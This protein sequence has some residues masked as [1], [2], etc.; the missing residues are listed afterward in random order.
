[1][2]RVLLISVVSIA[3]LVP[4]A[5][6]DHTPAA[7]PTPLPCTYTLSTVALS[8][9]ATGGSGSVAVTTAVGCAWTATSDRAWI[10]IVSSASGTGNGTVEVSVAANVSTGERAG[11]LTIAG[12]PVAV[13]V[14]ALAVEPCTFDLS[15]ASATFDHASGTGSFTVS[16]PDGCE[17]TA[18]SRVAWLAVTSGDHGSG[19]GRVAYAVDN[20]GTPDSR[21]GMIAIA[22]RMFTVTQSGSP[23]TCEYSVAPVTVAA[24]MSVPY[25]M[26]TTIAT[27]NGCSWT[28]TAGAPWISIRNQTGS[29]PATVRFTV[30][31]NWDAPRNSLVMIRWPTPTAGQNVQIAQA[32]CRY[33]VSASSIAVEA[34]GGSRSFD[35]YQ[36]SDP[37]D[38][39]GPLQDACVWTAQSGADWITISSPA[40]QRGDQRV[41]LV[42]A[43]NASAAPRTGVVTVRDK[44]VTI[45]QTGR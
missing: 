37:L 32:G 10:S 13:H 29:G 8:F 27:T 45:T 11:T 1:V 38:C 6:C 35:V 5:A 17:W 12:Q 14:A 19:A 2:R 16:A 7:Q 42:V 28:A 4:T 33:A 18:Q 40:T 15:P 26:A 21:T 44:T 23:L 30:S 39:G 9:G 20:N 41:S 25:D 31:D 3:L 43:P 36:Q 24:C 22:D 34:A